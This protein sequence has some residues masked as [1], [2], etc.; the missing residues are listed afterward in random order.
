MIQQ[1]TCIIK[2]RSRGEAYQ[3]RQI[4][5]LDIIL[6]HEL[7]ELV[8]IAHD[9]LAVVKFDGALADDR[10]E[11]IGSIRQVKELEGGLSRLC[12]SGRCCS[13]SLRRLRLG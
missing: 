7:V 13:C 10:R 4:P 2:D 3:T 8:Q 12:R 9:V 1:L 6:M 5:L 11:R